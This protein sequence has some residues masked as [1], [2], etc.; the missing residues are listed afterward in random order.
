MTAPT[1]DTGGFLRD[2]VPAGGN[3]RVRG[4]GRLNMKKSG[5]L[6]LLG[7]LFL[8]IVILGILG[9]MGHMIMGLFMMVLALIGA[10]CL[11]KKLTG[12]EGE[13]HLNRS[14][15]SEGGQGRGQTERKK[16]ED[17]AEIPGP[18]QVACKHCGTIN[19]LEAETCCKCGWPLPAKVQKAAA[20]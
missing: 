12:I 16:I 4:S 3:C 8:G 15:R 9:R 17:K 7:I 6:E 11:F 13:V 18:W 20:K 10:V 2:A 5:I 14:G 1:D 19:G